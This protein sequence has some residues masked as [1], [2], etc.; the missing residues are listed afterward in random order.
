V[1][2]S[3]FGVRFEW[4]EQGARALAASTDVI[5]IVDVLSFSTACLTRRAGPAISIARSACCRSV[6]RTRTRPD[7]GRPTAHL[8]DAAVFVVASFIERAARRRET[9]PPVAERFHHQQNRC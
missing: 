6:C 7:C 2:Q 4:G 9:G 8:D 3:A 1:N 5:V